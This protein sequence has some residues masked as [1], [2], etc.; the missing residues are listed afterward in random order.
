MIGEYEIF[1]IYDKIQ[2][3]GNGSCWYHLVKGCKSNGIW[4]KCDAWCF[5]EGDKGYI[6]NCYMDHDKRVSSREI[7]G[8]IGGELI[9]NGDICV[10]KYG[11]NEYVN[12]L[13][14]E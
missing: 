2:D 14:W 3:W 12:W 7:E 13:L 1:F 8:M 9:N 10:G 4:Y 6:G 5:W 11:V